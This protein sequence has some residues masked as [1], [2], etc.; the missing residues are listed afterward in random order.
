MAGVNFLW[1]SESRGLH[2]MAEPSTSETAPPAT[3]TPG[4]SP[5]DARLQRLW[6]AGR[7]LQHTADGD[8]CAVCLSRIT[9]PDAERGDGCQTVQDTPGSEAPDLLELLRSP[10]APDGNSSTRLPCGHVFHT[11]CILSWLKHSTSSDESSAGQTAGLIGSCPV[12][13]RVVVSIPGEALRDREEINTPPTGR[14]VWKS[15]RRSMFLFRVFVSVVVG[16]ILVFSIRGM[17]LNDIV[18][19]EVDL[20]E[21]QPGDPADVSPGKGL[22]PGCEPAANSG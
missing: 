8:S 22:C 14:Y 17:I 16:A 15:N 2:Q 18:Q 3:E 10:P 5:A 12:C 4:T 9:E 20:G 19:Q 13:R 7:R 11:D 6:M 1:L 21:E